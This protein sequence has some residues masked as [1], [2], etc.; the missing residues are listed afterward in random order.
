MPL[1]SQLKE[2]IIKYAQ[3]NGIKK[4]ILF[5]SRARGDNHERSDIDLAVSGGNPIRFHGDL[6]EGAHTRLIFDVVDLERPSLSQE[7]RKKKQKDGEIIYE[8]I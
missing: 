3:I 4:V 7:L 1:T 8:K 5:G 6:E 2:E